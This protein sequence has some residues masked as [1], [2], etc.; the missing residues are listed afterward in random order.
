MKAYECE[1]QMNIFDI[2]AA[3]QEPK[4]KELS[5]EIL[6]HLIEEL[7]EIFTVTE[8]KYEVWDHVPNLGKRMTATLKDLP[9]GWDITEIMD[10]YLKD[11]QLELHTTLMPPLKGGRNEEIWISTMWKTKGHKERTDWKEEQEK[12]KEDVMRL[13]L[14]RKYCMIIGVECAC[15]TEKGC[16]YP[17]KCGL[18]KESAEYS[19]LEREKKMAADQS[20]PVGTWVKSHGRRVLF[21]EIKVGQYYIADYSNESRE[22]LKIVYTKKKVEDKLMYVDSP[23]GVNGEWSWGNSYSAM[24]RQE[25]IDGEE[26]NC[27]WWYELAAVE[28]KTIRQPCGRPCDV[29]WCSKKCFIKRG[30]IWNTQDGGWARNSQGEILRT[31]NREC[32]WEPD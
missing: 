26:K 6:K 30:N 18:L 27:S 9:D 4:A 23:R 2:L 10:R 25:Y 13:P 1:G 7:K 15:H 31:K 32:D 29:E 28:E 21:D 8:I 20:E 14:S 19:N 17:E 12:S 11:Y 3:E 16:Q 5:N 22:S 24:T